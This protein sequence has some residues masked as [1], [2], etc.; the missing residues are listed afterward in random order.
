MRETF[1]IIIREDGSRVVRRRLDEV[2]ESARRAGT[3]VDFLKKLLATLGGL[4][5]ARSLLQTIDTFTN[6]ENR[7]RST[8]LEGQQLTSVYKE[9]LAVSNQTRSSVE[10]S[11]ELYARLAISSKELGVSQRQLIDFTKSLNQAIILSGASATEAQAGL[12]QLSQGMASGT[13]RGDELRSVLEQ[14]PAVADV[15]AKQLGVTRGELRKMGEDGKITARTILDAFQASRQELE[16][17]FGKTLPTLGQ[18]FQVLRNNVV[19]YVG[20]TDK[21]LGISTALSELMLG[22]ANNLDTAARAA[23]GLAAGLVLV[24]GTA[25]VLRAAAGAVA[26]LT[27]AIAA[28]PVGFLLVVLTSAI[29]TLTLFRDKILLGVDAVTT[30]GDYMRAFRDLVEPAFNALLD[31]GSAV[32]GSLLKD[33]QDWAKGTDFSIAGILRAA[34]RGVDFFVGLWA[35]AVRAT[36][37]IFEGVPPA[38][39]DLFTRALNVVLSKISTFVNTAGELLSTVTEFAGLGKISANLDFTLDNADAGAAARLGGDIAKSFTEGFESANGALRV[40]DSLIEKAK[41]YG[42]ARA[43][44]ERLAARNPLRV[45]ETAGPA[46]PV[47]LDSKEVLKAENALRSLLNTIKPSEGA[48]LELA[49]AERVLDAAVGKGLITRQQANDYLRIAQRYYQDAIDPLGAYNRQLDEQ[50]ALLR[51]ATGE[52]QS[53]AEVLRVVKDLQSQGIDL[54]TAEV[55][56]LRTKI[57]ALEQLNA[58]TQAQDALYA[59]SI[60][61]RKEFEVQLQALQALSQVPDFTAGDQAGAVSGILESAGLDLEGTKVLQDAQVAQF[62]QMYD[63]IA[64]LRDAHVLGEQDAQ[65]LLAQVA[66]ESNKARLQG[67]QQFFGT[68][69]QL[70]TSGNKKLAAIGRAAAIAQATIDGI[71]AV[72]KALTAA[73]PPFNYALAAAVG[74]TAAANVAQIAGIGFRDGG[75]TGNGGRS[76]VAGIVHGQEFVVNAEG[77][78]R[79]RSALEAMNRGGTASSSGGGQNISIVVNNNAEGTTSRE[80]VRDTPDGKEIEITIERVV[81]ANV[82]SGGKIA[83]TFEAQYDLNRALGTSR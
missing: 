34:A 6:L 32:F 24:G 68:L 11:V 13:L 37:A 61:K 63:Q 57:T 20:Q 83:Q 60:G 65:Q 52:R 62:Q 74:V 38:L 12:I 33:V 64:A 76:S 3:G 16:E 72:Q 56:A 73:P 43:E 9:L 5:A 17:R 81:I 31:V 8:G 27:A 4:A 59:Q 28:N 10:G 2:G 49:R 18:S 70:S 78:A 51:V 15:I 77:T 29:A 35:G 26:A 48:V 46:A 36:V 47:K 22:L 79:N 69:A 58:V 75:Y 21:A 23:L 1:D 44:V 80:S 30:L 40:V 53:E 7:L 50:A 25:G 71:L 66:V 55:A 19:D 45:S 67:T 41:E 82:R 14:L 42:Q 39:S 54:T